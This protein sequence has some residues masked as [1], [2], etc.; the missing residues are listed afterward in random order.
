MEI[1]QRE[2]LQGKGSLEEV[3]PWLCQRQVSL[4]GIVVSA[5]LKK[6]VTYQSFL[7][8]LQKNAIAFMDATISCDPVDDDIERIAATFF[9]KGIQVVLGLGGGS[10]LDSAKAISILDQKHLHILKYR[11]MCPQKQVL[12]ICVPSTLGTG[13]EVSQTIV[14]KDH[15]DGIKKRITHEVIKADLIVLDPL[16]TQTLPSSIVK[17]TAVDAL[18]HSLEGITN[19]TYLRTRDPQIK[20]AAYQA[21]SLILTNLTLALNHPLD[22]NAKEKLQWAAFYGGVCM[23]ND[24]NACHVLAGALHQ[25]CPSMCHGTAVGILLGEVV[26][27][28]QDACQDIYADIER[29]VFHTCGS[30]QELANQFVKRIHHFLQEIKFP[31]LRDYLPLNQDRLIQKMKDRLLVANQLN[32]FSLSFTDVT[33]IM[34]QCLNKTSSDGAIG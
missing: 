21:I 23:Q 18:A 11:T 16:V 20:D 19:I 29:S 5:T 7:L 12:L 10:V 31:I 26:E 14:V 8:Q 24:L 1:Y 33:T 30:D 3:V 13:S 2:V 6:T 28:N 15:N 22:I 9:A 4:I 27:M 17:T 34:Q 25:V 32:P